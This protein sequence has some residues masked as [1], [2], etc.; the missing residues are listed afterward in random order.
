[1]VSTENESASLIDGH[2]LVIP[3]TNDGSLNDTFTTINLN[4][5]ARVV[6]RK[7][8]EEGRVS[9]STAISRYK[10]TYEKKG[11]RQI[12]LLQCKKVPQIKH[13]K[14]VRCLSKNF[15]SMVLKHVTQW[16]L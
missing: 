3:E 15:H 11:S 13:L 6:G 7:L 9:R 1:M 12:S 16:K 4:E 2:R 8:F 10:T 14:N 5:D